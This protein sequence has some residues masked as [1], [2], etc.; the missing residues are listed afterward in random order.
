VRDGLAGRLEEVLGAEAVVATTD[1]GLTLRPPSEDAVAAAVRLCREAH[2]PLTPVG[3]G[4]QMEVGGPPAGD[5]LR[6]SLSRLNALVEH[7][8]ANLTITAQAGMTAAGLQAALAQSRQFAVIDTPRPDR[9]T[10]GGLAAT[11]LNGYRRTAYRSIRDL[12]I[13]MRLVTGT[14][15]IVKAGGKVV[16]N[17]A[18]YDMC[19][20]F[21]GSLGTLGVIT[22]MTARVEPLPEAEATLVLSFQGDTGDGAHDAL[23]AAVRVAG[24]HLLPTAVALVNTAAALRVTGEP[25]AAALVRLEGFSAVMERQERD[26]RAVGSGETRRVEAPEHA[27]MWGRLLALGWDGPGGLIRMTMPRSALP[28][29]WRALDPIVGVGEMA[30]DLLSGTIWVAAQ[31]EAFPGV[32]AIIA[33]LVEDAGGHLLI[34]RMPHALTPL[35][36]RDRWRRAPPGQ[37]RL[38]GV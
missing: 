14:G 22:Q 23:E 30:A 38:G 32:A 25:R 8:D 11:N 4:T 37:P 5:S 1:Q 24:S 21:V 19:K 28:A 6:L 16:K 17:V 9:A 18:G 20:L 36:A 15:E 12:V 3:G 7:D 34:V 10:L 13:G 31:P 26:V 33:S 35:P 2:T 29:A 27:S